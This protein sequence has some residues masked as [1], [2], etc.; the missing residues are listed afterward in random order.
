MHPP[1]TCLQQSHALD[2]PLGVLLRKLQQQQQQQTKKISRSTS[3]T[4]NMHP[5]LTQCTMQL[6][7]LL[8]LHIN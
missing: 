5:T 3:G 8:T 6:E 1:G 4:H 7:L 2:G